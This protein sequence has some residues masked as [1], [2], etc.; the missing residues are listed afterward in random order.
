[1]VL[2]VPLMLV[3]ML[4]YVVLLEQ[5]EVEAHHLENVAFVIATCQGYQNSQR[6]GGQTSRLKSDSP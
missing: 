5:G 1:M 2:K 3:T 6:P 4:A